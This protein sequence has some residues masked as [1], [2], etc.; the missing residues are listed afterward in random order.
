MESNFLSLSPIYVYNRTR[1]A[2]ASTFAEFGIEFA[3]L[4]VCP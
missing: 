4:R 3:H 2:A 1:E